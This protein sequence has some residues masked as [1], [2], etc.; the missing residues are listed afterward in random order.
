MS[1][2]RRWLSASSR[3]QH[4][5]KVFLLVG[6]FDTADEH[7][8]L[9]HRVGLDFTFIKDFL[10]KHRQQLLAS[11]YQGFTLASS[12][13][14]DLFLSIKRVGNAIIFFTLNQLDW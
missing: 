8:L 2:Q 4:V 12:P 9:N 5:T 3:N 10:R 6:G 13:A 1:F 7:R 14:L 11:A